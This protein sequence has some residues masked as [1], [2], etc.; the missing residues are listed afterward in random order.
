MQFTLGLIFANNHI[1]SGKFHVAE[2]ANSFVIER[3]P[4]AKS[5]ACSEG[6]PVCP[7]VGGSLEPDVGIVTQPLSIGT[8]NDKRLGKI[9]M[10]ACQ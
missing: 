7:V 3:V 9:L 8:L 5:I 10:P 2:N 4:V 1:M 6:L